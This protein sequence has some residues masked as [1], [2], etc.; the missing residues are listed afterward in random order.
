MAGVGPND[1]WLFVEY[2]RY[3]LVTNPWKHDF[4]DK[5]TSKPL[6]FNV[7]LVC[8]F[9]IFGSFLI[10]MLEMAQKPPKMVQDGSSH[11][12]LSKNLFFLGQLTISRCGG[13][14]FFKV[15][16]KKTYFFP[17]KT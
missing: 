1:C 15:C 13:D 3:N 8:S 2:H 9:Q 14:L 12:Y 7:F 4:V 10:K 16:C 5:H 11:A 17:G 6:F